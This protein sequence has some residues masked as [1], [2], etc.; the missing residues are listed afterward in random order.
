MNWINLIERAAWTFIEAFLIALPST[1][2][3]GVE[4]S[5]GVSALLSAAC[6]GLSALKTFVIEFVKMRRAELETP[7]E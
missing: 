6:A 2:S 4:G 3:F 1:I 7:K 5:L